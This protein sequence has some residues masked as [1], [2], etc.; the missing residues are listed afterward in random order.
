MNTYRPTALLST[1]AKL[2]KSIIGYSVLGLQLAPHTLSG[3]NVCPNASKGCAAA[4]LFSAGM[5]RMPA[6]IK[7]RINKTK[8]FFENRKAFM[9]QLCEEI[10]IEELRAKLHGEKLA[11][12]LNTISDLTWESIK[13]ENGKSVFDNFPNVQFYDY[14]KNPKRALMHALGQMPANYHL[15]FS[16]S[17]EN[18]FHVDIVL[19]NGG[20]VAVVFAGK[21]PDTYKGKMVISGDENDGRFLDPKNVVVG[22]TAKGKAKKDNSGF[23]VQG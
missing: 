4:C 10:A 11:I 20:N 17:E 15:T 21:L 16:R 2:K 18:D 13:C 23:V 6:V 22:L 5:G 7:G 19:A 9:K 14:T 3:K 8:F 1:N 12:R